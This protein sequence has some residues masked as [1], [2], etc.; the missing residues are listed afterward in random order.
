M[1]VTGAALTVSSSAV[2]VLP[3]SGVTRSAR[4]YSGETT[5]PSRCSGSP[6]PL[7]ATSVEVNDAMCSNDRADA[8]SS[9]MCGRDQRSRDRP[10]RGVTCVLNR[11]TRRSGSANGSGRSSAA[12]A[13]RI[14]AFHRPFHQIYSSSFRMIRTHP[15]K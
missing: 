15:T 11:M 7:V 3:A 6:S 2:N 4:K 12:P 13:A 9:S 8:C 14:H 1:T 5:S 10:S